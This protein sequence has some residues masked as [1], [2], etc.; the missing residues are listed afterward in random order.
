M[1]KLKSKKMTKSTFA[2]IIMAGFIYGMA[3]DGQLIAEYATFTE[4]PDNVITFQ[5]F[6]DDFSICHSYN[7]IK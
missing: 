7:S 6:Q 1:T 3:I 4:S 2:I 5:L